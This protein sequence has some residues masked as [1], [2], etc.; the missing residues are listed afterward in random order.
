[1]ILTY[2]AHKRVIG[3][4]NLK[5]CSHYVMKVKSMFLVNGLLAATSANVLY[6]WAETV[7]WHFAENSTTTLEEK[8]IK[9]RIIILKI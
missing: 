8:H 1:M 2:A 4:A 6:S 5:V 3:K 7:L 9:I